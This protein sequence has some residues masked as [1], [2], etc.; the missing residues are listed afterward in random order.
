MESAEDFAWA[1]ECAAR[2]GEE[3][4]LYLQPEWSRYEAVIGEVVEYAKAHP[5]W[6]VSVQVHKFMHIP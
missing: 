1:E 3:C 6:N 2:V 4:L 5:R